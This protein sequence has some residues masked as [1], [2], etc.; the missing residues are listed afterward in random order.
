MI[1]PWPPKQPEAHLT[2]PFLAGHS[3]AVA[4]RPIGFDISAS[5]GEPRQPFIRPNSFSF[6][7]SLHPDATLQLL[8]VTGDV[9][10]ATYRCWIADELI[11]ARH[12]ELRRD[13]TEIEA[14]SREDAAAQALVRFAEIER[15]ELEGSEEIELGHIQCELVQG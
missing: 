3:V 4:F 8:V 10:M 5:N 6:C 1:L 13:Q 11:A 14:D 9:I 12:P 7:P 2:N 15:A